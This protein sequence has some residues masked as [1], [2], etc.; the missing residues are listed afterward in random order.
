MPAL[1]TW[2]S[3][4]PTVFSE[5]TDP[6][7]ESKSEGEWALGIIL[8][9]AGAAATNLGLTIQKRS[10][11]LNDAL[12][13]EMQKPASSQSLWVGGLFVFLLGQTANL[14]AFGYTSQAVAATL[15]SFSLV[16]NG[17]F[18]PLLLREKLNRQIVLSIGIICAGSVAVVLSSS[19]APQEYSLEELLHLLQRPLFVMYLSAL[20]I[21]FLVSVSIMIFLDRQW[22]RVEA[23]AAEWEK[24]REGESLEYKPSIAGGTRM[25]LDP[26]LARNS[27]A[28][29]PPSSEDAFKIVH[30]VPSSERAWHDPSPSESSALLGTTGSSPEDSPS[31]LSS[32]ASSTKLTAPGSL[33]PIVAAAVLSSLSVL[34]G[35]CT[36]Q[37]LKD[38]LQRE[39]QFRSPLSWV[40][41]V[42]FLFCAVSAVAFLNVGLRRGKALFVVPLYYVLNTILAITGG[43][44]Y[45]EEFRRFGVA[46]GIVFASGVAVTIGG[47]WVSSRGQVSI[48]DGG[49][50]EDSDVE[51][52]GETGVSRVG[53]GGEES[54]SESCDEE[55]GTSPA[56]GVSASS[57]AESPL[58]EEVGGEAAQRIGHQKAPLPPAAVSSNI[59]PERKKK[60]GAAVRFGA[61]D[62]GSSS[63]MKRAVSAPGVGLNPET[64]AEMEREASI[65]EIEEGDALKLDAALSTPQPSTRS[66]GS[67]SSTAAPFRTPGPTSRHLQQEF[68]S[69]A[70]A[71]SAAR[72]HHHHHHH[73]PLIPSRTRSLSSLTARSQQ[74]VLTA[75]ASVRDQQLKDALMR[76]AARKRFSLSHDA[77]PSSFSHL[78]PASSGAASDA[79][80]HPTPPRVERRYSVAIVGLGIS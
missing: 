32:P 6:S 71:A 21:A 50:E 69:A 53:L 61:A 31:S 35:K 27:H 55:G 40:L 11:L 75:Q 46:Q 30:V 62:A 5:P 58:D 12:P 4:D 54:A 2:M 8:C 10:F 14:L 22:A 65:E 17:I 80:R 44:V 28:S 66:Y 41:T 47:V 7:A 15:G 67:L 59:S 24:R 52:G 72:K 37:L 77:Y 9:L 3:L 51:L 25:E 63:R 57:E 16:T 43:L 68:P 48:E 64:L 23:E 18:A 74:Q 13:L 19:R 49:I 45:F 38:S 36:V 73:R 34:F 70:A 26:E 39:N 33:T 76:R 79:A 20:V 42:V 60:L 29:P 1:A 56:S 78:P